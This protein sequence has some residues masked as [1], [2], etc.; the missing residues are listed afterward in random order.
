MVTLA[1]T[2]FLPGRIFLFSI[3]L[4]QLPLPTWSSFRGEGSIYTCC[5]GLGE[6]WWAMIAGWAGAYSKAESIRSYNLAL[7]LII[8]HIDYTSSKISAPTDGQPYSKKGYP[9]QHLPNP[10]PPNTG[11]SYRGASRSYG[12]T[13]IRYSTGRGPHNTYY[14]TNADTR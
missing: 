14:S 3:F 8:N 10:H 2:Y 13:G 12:K 4:Y 6:L 11:I 5:R 1:F 7:E 9:T